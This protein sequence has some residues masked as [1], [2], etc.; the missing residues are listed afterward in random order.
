MSTIK[1]YPAQPN[2][3]KAFGGISPHAGYFFSGKCANQ[4][5]SSVEIPQHVL[6]LSV[7]HR[8]HFDY[9]P[10]FPSG[11]WQTPIGNVKISDEL[12]AE[13]IKLDFVKFDEQ[14]H[15][16]EH[17]GE[18][19]LPF[20]KFYRDDVMISVINVGLAPLYHQAGVELE[21]IQEFGSEIGKVLKNFNQDVLVVASSDMSHEDSHETS[22]T[23]DKF[24]LEAI[25]EFDTERLYDEL[26][27]HSISMCGGIPALI[28]F[29]ATKVMGAT[30]SEILDYYTSAD[31]TREKDNFTVGY[32]ACRIS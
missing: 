1:C 6:V 18:I 22:I 32:C 31:V 2:K 7:S 21:T 4:F 8:M 16:G 9:L 23:K 26:T 19:Q 30:K 27:K 3:I 14:A 10:L 24:A 25:S 29:E 20:L 17:S 5:Y 28:M 11:S 15:F 12:N 13:L